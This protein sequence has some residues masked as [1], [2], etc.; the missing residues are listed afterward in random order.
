MFGSYGQQ[1]IVQSC[2]TEGSEFLAVQH[3]VIAIF[4]C[5]LLA[6][7]KTRSDYGV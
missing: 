4:S 7:Q 5:K 2:F 3:A 6:N 1:N